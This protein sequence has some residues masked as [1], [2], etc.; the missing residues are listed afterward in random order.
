MKSVRLLGIFI[1]ISEKKAKNQM[2][3][4]DSLILLIEIDMSG[5][6]DGHLRHR[7]PLHRTPL[8]DCHACR[9][10]LISSCG[11]PAY[12]RPPRVHLWECQHEF[13]WVEA[14]RVARTWTN[15]VYSTLETFIHSL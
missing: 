8:D 7:N 13:V 3:V 4:F 15:K 11:N 2:S 9:H 5:H 1:Q 10:V 6:L 12:A 14:T